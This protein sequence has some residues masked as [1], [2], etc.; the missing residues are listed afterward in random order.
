MS[1]TILICFC[2]F[3]VSAFA[4]GPVASVSS[5][6]DF[7]LHGAKVATA[8][9]P[10]WPVMAGDSILAGTTSARVRFQDGTTVTL[11]PGSEARVEQS[12]QGLLF[13]LVSGGMV[14][15]YAPN[16][17]VGMFSGQSALTAAAGTPT[18]AGTVAADGTPVGN[19]GSGL[20]AGKNTSPI[21]LSRR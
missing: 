15:A 12:K 9:V 14:F 5:G 8:G 2:I 18:F 6:S 16:S 7:M 3:A 17:S 13:R 11:S 1:R 10:V 4:A 19:G 21:A 20:A